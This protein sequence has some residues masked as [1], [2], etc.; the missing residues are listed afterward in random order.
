MQRRNTLQRLRV[1]EAIDVLGHPTS[2][3]L[4]LYMNKTHPDVSL[5]TIYRNLSILLEDGVVI[6]LKLGNSNIYE[7]VKEKHYHFVCREC[8][9]IIDIPLDKMNEIM[10]PKEIMD[11][12]IVDHDFVFFGYCKNCKKIIRKEDEKNEEVCM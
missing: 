2:D 1:K 4:I 11:N 3:E 6:K 5:A 7:A 8:K 9:N 12:Q 10:I